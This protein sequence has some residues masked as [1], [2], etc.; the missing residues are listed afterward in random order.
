MA[1]SMYLLLLNMFYFYVIN[2]F[3]ALLTVYLIFR[4]YKN[5]NKFS[6]KLDYINF[7]EISIKLYV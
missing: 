7:N 6:L 4:Y 1:F 5:E 2:Y 3:V